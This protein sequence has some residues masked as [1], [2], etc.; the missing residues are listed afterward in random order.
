MAIIADTHMHSSFSGDSETPMEQMVEK[1]IALGFKEICF[2]EHMD[3][4]FTYIEGEP[5]DMFEV[6]VDAYLYDLLRLRHKYEGRIKILFGIELG[7][8]TTV[9]RKNTL[10]C[11]EHEFDFII[12]SQHL[13]NGKDPYLKDQFFGGRSEGEAVHEYFQY[14]AEC[15]RGFQNFDVYGHLDYVLRYGPS[16]GKDFRFEEYREDIDKV[17]KLLIENEKGIEANTSGYAYGMGGPHPRLEILKRYRELGGEIIT[18]GSD[19]HDTEH[20]GQYFNEVTELLKEAGFEYYCV[21]ENR[22]P[23]YHRL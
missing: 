20:M 14:M 4:D 3:Y 7:M 8:Q 22:Y 9:A 16:Q 5:E 2:T 10:L 6:N 19:A 18:I 21:F 11:K 12:A 15:I 17:L 23:E 1:G 13:C